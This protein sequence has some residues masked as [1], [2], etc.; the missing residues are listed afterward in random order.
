MLVNHGFSNLVGIDYLPE[1][2]VPF[3]KNSLEACPIQKI[4]QC[5]GGLVPSPLEPR[6]INNF[7]TDFGT[8][9]CNV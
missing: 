3:S 1:F 5:N 2:L 6:I 7:P 9:V 4:V 8:V